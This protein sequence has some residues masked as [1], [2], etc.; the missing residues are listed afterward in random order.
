MW[1]FTNKEVLLLLVC[2]V[3]AAWLRFDGLTRGTS[4]FVLPEQTQVGAETVFYNFHPDEETLVR[5]VLRLDNP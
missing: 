2:M 5:A 3:L 1:K 4:D